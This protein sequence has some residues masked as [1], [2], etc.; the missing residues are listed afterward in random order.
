M[1][2]RPVDSIGVVVIQVVDA[3]LQLIA[4][5]ALVNAED[6]EADV[7][8]QGELVHGVNSAHVIEHEEQHR[9]PLGT[10]TVS[11]YGVKKS[12]GYRGAGTPEIL[13]REGSQV[14]MI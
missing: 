10:R 14:N 13:G 4:A 6:K 5:V 11:L 7:G 2:I 1:V 3:V 12:Q 8:I 9:G